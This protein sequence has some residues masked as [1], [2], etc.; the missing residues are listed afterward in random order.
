MHNIARQETLMNKTK[1]SFS[2][3]TPHQA[4]IEGQTPHRNLTDDPNNTILD[5]HIL[6]ANDE[7]RCEI[8]L[9]KPSTLW[10]TA[11]IVDLTTLSMVVPW[12]VGG[13]APADEDELGSDL[14]LADPSTVVD[15][16]SDMLAY[17]KMFSSSRALPGYCKCMADATRRETRPSA[18]SWG[19]RVAVGGA[20]GL[21]STAF[22]PAGVRRIGTIEVKRPSKTAN[23]VVLLSSTPIQ[24]LPC[25]W[26][27]PSTPDEARPTASLPTPTMLESWRSSRSPREKECGLRPIA[28]RESDTVVDL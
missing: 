28:C 21:P 22:F 7:A 24:L 19:K 1:T 12:G 16:A 9:R 20:K 2:H 27:T 23:I 17:A 10:P 26:E 11:W 25:P 15:T 8:A 6:V 18:A 4:T 5:T 14:N 13:V 3:H